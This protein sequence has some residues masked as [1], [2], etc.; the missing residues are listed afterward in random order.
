MAIIVLA[1]SSVPGEVIGALVLWCIALSFVWVYLSNRQQNWWALIPGGVM[2]IAGLAPVV[3]LVSDSP[4][5]IGGVFFLGLAA[6]FGLLYFLNPSGQERKW[7]VYPA[8]I[9][10][11]I[12]LGVVIL[13]QNWWPVVIIAL[14]IFLLINAL[15][16]GH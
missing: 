9:L 2:F 10:A 13:G 11:V 16:R 12:G 5:L 4:R 15:R 8:S 6:V 3:T 14:G 1:A 7:A